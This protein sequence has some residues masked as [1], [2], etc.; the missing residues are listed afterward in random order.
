MTT[1]VSVSINT[2]ITDA[3]NTPVDPTKALKTIVFYITEALLFLIAIISYELKTTILQLEYLK[4]D[5]I[6]AAITY[7]S[8]MPHPNKAFLLVINVPLKILTGHLQDHQTHYPTALNIKPYL[9]AE[10]TIKSHSLQKAKNHLADVLHPPNPGDY[11]TTKYSSDVHITDN[12][13]T[14]PENNPHN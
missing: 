14:N 8:D 11:C 9:K 5:L 1:L 3:T 4:Q 2:S 13:N 12:M 7:K 6:D 10:A